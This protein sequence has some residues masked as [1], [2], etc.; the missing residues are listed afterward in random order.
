MEV[1]TNY[2]LTDVVPDLDF[3]SHYMNQMEWKNINELYG[4]HKEYTDTMTDELPVEQYI[5]HISDYDMPLKKFLIKTFKRWGIKTQDF[6][7]D[8]FLTKPGGS[9]PAHIDHKS[10]I[11]MLF[12]LVENTGVL[13]VDSCPD[14][15]YNKMLILNTQA[16]H[17]VCSPEK[18]RLLFRIA[19]HDFLFENLSYEQS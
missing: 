6:R 15:V 12:P 13:K 16:E 1:K 19:I 18:D 17:Q 11:A 4:N 8:F 2:I 9:L 10:K 5:K 7:C 14:I 3:F